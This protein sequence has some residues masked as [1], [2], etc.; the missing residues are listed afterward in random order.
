MVKYVSLDAEGGPVLQTALS[1]SPRADT[2]CLTEAAA[3]QQ[4]DGEA[5]A[6]MSAPDEALGS[7]HCVHLSEA[8]ENQLIIQ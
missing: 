7:Q 4:A 2:S 5:C 6:L 1:D 3:K 8:G